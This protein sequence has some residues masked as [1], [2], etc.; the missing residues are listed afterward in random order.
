MGQGCHLERLV[1]VFGRYDLRLMGLLVENGVG[2]RFALIENGYV[3]VGISAPGHL[4]LPQ[5]IGGTLGQASARPSNHWCGDPSICTSSPKHARLSRN[6]CATIL[7]ALRA[8]HSPSSIMIW[9]T[10]STDS[11][12]LSFSFSFSCASVGPNPT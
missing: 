6:W 9:R 3:L 8:F 12:S 7:R 10:L 2:Q 5:G 11:F 4:S 1:D